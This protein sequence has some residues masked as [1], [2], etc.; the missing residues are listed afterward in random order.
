MSTQAYE[1]IKKIED[2]VGHTINNRRLRLH[3]ATELQRALD[4][5]SGLRAS[6]KNVLDGDMTFDPT[7]HKAI[8]LSDREKGV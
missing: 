2:H 1:I 6:I 7:T 8:N 3:L 4:R 5:E